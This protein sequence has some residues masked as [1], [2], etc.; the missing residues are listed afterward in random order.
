[1]FRPVFEKLGGLRA[2]TDAPLMALTASAISDVQKLIQS[3]LHLHDPVVVSKSLDLF[4]S[5]GEIKGY[6]VSALQAL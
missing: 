6:T 1:M 4:F 3:S 5:V 2:F